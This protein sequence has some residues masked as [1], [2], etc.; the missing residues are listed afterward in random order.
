MT[1]RDSARPCLLDCAHKHVFE[2]LYTLSREHAVLS[3]RLPETYGRVRSMPRIDTKAS[4]LLHKGT[5]CGAGLPPPP[6][7][8]LQPSKPRVQDVSVHFST[9]W[10]LCKCLPETAIHL[11]TTV[12]ILSKA[13]CKYV[14]FMCIC[15]ASESLQLWT[16]EAAAPRENNHHLFPFQTGPGRA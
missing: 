8:L 3:G 10:L 9:T 7:L 13:K 2:A 6:T 4:L 12:I 16:L 15:F 1:G 11:R 5:V 14:P